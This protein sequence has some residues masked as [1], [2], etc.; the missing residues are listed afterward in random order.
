MVKSVVLPALMGAADEATALRE[1][2]RALEA[3]NERLRE[4]LQRVKGD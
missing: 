1:R 2:V 4:A 3:E